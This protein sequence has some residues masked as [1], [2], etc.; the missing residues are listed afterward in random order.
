MRPRRSAV[1]AVTDSVAS[2]HASS[3]TIV[4]KLEIVWAAS[5]CRHAAMRPSSSRAG[6]TTIASSAMALPGR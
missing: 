1:R 6:M 2:A 4:S 3:T 5:A